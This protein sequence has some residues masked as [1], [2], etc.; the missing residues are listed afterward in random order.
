[1]IHGLKSINIPFGYIMYKDKYKLDEKELIVLIAIKFLNQENK[2]QMDYK[3]LAKITNYQTTEIQKIINK[4]VQKGILEI[5][6]IKLND[7]N[8]IIY[9]LD[10]FEDNITQ[11]AIEQ[12]TKMQKIEKLSEFNNFKNEL[13]TKVKR[14][15]NEIEEDHLKV[16]VVNGLN[17]KLF[18]HILNETKDDSFGQLIMQL[19]KVHAEQINTLSEYEIFQKKEKSTTKL[20]YSLNQFNW[21]KVK[22]KE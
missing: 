18:K 12:T 3:F 17:Y 10:K 2:T 15:L 1:M 4:L 21:F 8:E 22:N 6:L 5:Q 20:N 9:S 7:K 14:K 11:D 13:E 19:K 16:L